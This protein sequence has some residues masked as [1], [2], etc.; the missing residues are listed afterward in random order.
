MEE[1]VAIR[2]RN[3]QSYMCTYP[4]QKHKNKQKGSLPKFPVLHV[5]IPSTKTQT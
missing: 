1:A 4:L 5:Y 3:Y 2:C